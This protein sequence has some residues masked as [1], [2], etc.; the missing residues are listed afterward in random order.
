MI[1][2]SRTDPSFS[3]WP[4]AVIFL[5]CVFT[6]CPE[7]PVSCKAVWF[8]RKSLVEEATGEFNPEL[9]MDT[10]TNNLP[11]CTKFSVTSNDDA[12]FLTVDFKSKRIEVD[13]HGGDDE[14][15]NKLVEMVKEKYP[16]FLEVYCT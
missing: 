1:V 8:D 14:D 6:E 3:T 11:T 7:L 9:F 15:L 12:T 4:E 10:M 5:E 16:H 13:S 2:K